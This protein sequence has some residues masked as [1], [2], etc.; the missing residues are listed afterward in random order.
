MGIMATQ[1]EDACA[2][3]N[4]R[5]DFPVAFR[6]ERDG[7]RQHN[8][9]LSVC[10]GEEQWLIG[11]RL[12]LAVEQ[13]TSEVPNQAKDKNLQSEDLHSEDSAVTEESPSKMH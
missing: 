6:R 2:I 10:S 7:M 11:N 4:L 9:M 3:W 12:R 5:N 1:E 13:E 8:L